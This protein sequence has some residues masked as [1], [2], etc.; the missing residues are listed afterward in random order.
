MKKEMNRPVPV[1]ASDSVGVL[2]ETNKN[3]NTSDAEWNVTIISTGTT[4]LLWNENSKD[5]KWNH[6]H[7][8][9]GTR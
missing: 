9:G 5:E 3:M 8:L 7:N 6:S 4:V 2:E 1:I